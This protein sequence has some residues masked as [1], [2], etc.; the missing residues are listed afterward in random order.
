MTNTAKKFYD[1]T[2]KLYDSRH[3][4]DTARYLRKRENKMIK[5]YA[6][7]K[8]IDIGC[9]TGCHLDAE[10]TGI[11]I[12]Y[13]MLMEC[14]SCKNL[15]QSRAEELPVKTS[16]FNTAIC[17]FSTL[18]L[19]DADK[20]TEEM[21]RIL[22]NNGI[23]IIS[24]S[25]V[26]GGEKKTKNMRIEGFRMKINTFTKKELIDLFRKNGFE[27]L[28]F[29]GMFKSQKPY[30]GWYRNFSLCEKIKL[31]LDKLPPSSRGRMYIAAFRKL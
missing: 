25:S 18:N 14:K 16:V 8:V 2:A 20:A 9:G 28:E 3:D 11:D 15:I 13:N 29:H 1:A 17:M 6:R 12:S 4:N 7:G 5:K 24:V 23:A 10:R 21:N 19:C 30:W 27:S 26:R 31:F 22:R